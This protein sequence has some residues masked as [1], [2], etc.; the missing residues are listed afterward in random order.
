MQIDAI[1]PYKF[2]TQAMNI[3]ARLP[4]AQLKRLREQLLR[5]DGDVEVELNG[6]VD[7]SGV[8][9]LR[10]RVQ[11]ELILSCQRCNEEMLI[12]VKS[13]VN[14]SPVMSES[15]ATS[16]P[17]GYDPLVTEGN[18]LKLKEL[19]EDELLLSIPMVPKHPE[20]ECPISFAQYLK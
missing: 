17:K 13:L 1:D 20:G 14:L 9:V 15:Q 7:E 12:P 5:T 3:K 11:C 10:L 16:V 2:A 8:K 19:V 6:V 4:L 18:S